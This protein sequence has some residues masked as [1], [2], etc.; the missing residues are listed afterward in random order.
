MEV[1][2]TERKKGVMYLHIDSYIH[3]SS[4]AGKRYELERYPDVDQAFDSWHV[5]CYDFDTGQIAFPQKLS[6]NH[7]RMSQ[8]EQYPHSQHGQL[9]DFLVIA[10]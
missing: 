7:S 2:K 8:G 10:E 1:K 4:P 6:K 3:I 5:S 9:I